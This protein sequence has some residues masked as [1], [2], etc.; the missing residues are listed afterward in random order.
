MD[1]SAIIVKPIITEKSMARAGSGKFTFAVALRT[2]K[3]AIKQAVEKQFGVHV[4]HVATSIVKG[5]TQRVGQKRLEIGVPEW[6][7]AVVTLEK[8][9]KISLFELGE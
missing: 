2:N 8:G 5:K 3:T 1:T 9:Q 7:K 6:K 4:L